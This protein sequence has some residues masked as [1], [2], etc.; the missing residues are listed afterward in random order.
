MA[1]QSKFFESGKIAGSFFR[2]YSHIARSRAGHLGPYLQTALLLLTLLSG[3]TWTTSIQAQTSY[4]SIIGSV[5]DPSGAVVPDAQVSLKNT[6][7]N[8]TQTATTSASG[9]YSFVNLNPGS[10]SVTVSKTDFQSFTQDGVDVQIGGAT[11]VNITLPVGNASETVTVTA[12]PAQLQTDSASLGGVVEGQ[13]VVESP[14]NGRNV[15]N[16]LDF[17]PGVVPG[18]WDSRQHDGQRRQRQ[19]SG[20]RANP[21]DCVWEL[22][23]R[24]RIQWAKYIFH[25]WR[26]VEHRRE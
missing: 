13:Q 18:G 7:T 6:G 8:A 11:R 19:L 1:S 24:R 14:L 15:N 26:Q 12:A 20:W 23:D 17:V 4:G 21:G 25:R 5:T 16:L 22:P 2:S 9:T 10:Y 3:I